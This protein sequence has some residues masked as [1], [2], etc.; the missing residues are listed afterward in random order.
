MFLVGAGLAH[1]VGEL[2]VF[3]GQDLIGWTMGNQFA[4]QH[5]GF[6]EVPAHGV[7]VVQNG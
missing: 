4:G 6:G 2:L 3:T 7:V 5:Q 1:P